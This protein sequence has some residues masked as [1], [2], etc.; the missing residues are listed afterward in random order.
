M[1]PPRCG[2]STCASAAHHGTG[3]LFSPRRG[4]VGSGEALPFFP[5]SMH[6]CHRRIGSCL[7]IRENHFKSQAP[8]TGAGAVEIPPLDRWTVG[9]HENGAA[10]ACSDLQVLTEAAPEHVYILCSHS[11]RCWAANSMVHGPRQLFCFSTKRTDPSITGKQNRTAPS[12]FCRL[13]PSV[14]R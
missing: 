13:P 7:A 6:A 8:W 10:S 11:G 9:I 1:R 2:R 14:F 12:I 5:S 3:S 4:R